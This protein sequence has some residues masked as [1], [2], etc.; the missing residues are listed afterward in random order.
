MKAS[1]LR[2]KSADELNQELLELLK[3]QFSLRMQLATQ[4]LGNTSQMGKVRR[5]IARVRTLL[6][7]KA[8]A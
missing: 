8:G 4:Q 2:A 5:D 1:E 7:E 6:R 3:A